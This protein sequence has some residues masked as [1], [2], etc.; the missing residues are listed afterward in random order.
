MKRITC[1]WL[2]AAALWIGAPEAEARYWLREYSPTGTSR[3]DGM[4][5][6]PDGGFLTAGTANADLWLSKMTRWGMMEWSTGY[7]AAAPTEGRAVLRTFDDGFLVV[8]SIRDDAVNLSTNVFVLRTDAEGVPLWA[9]SIGSQGDDAAVSVARTIGG[10]YL[11]GATG[12][13]T[14][15]GDDFYVM[16]LNDA[17][18]LIWQRFYGGA[19]HES[20]T[21]VGETF[22]GS[23]YI[24]GTTTSYGNGDRDLLLMRLAPD[25]VIENVMVVDVDGEGS[26]DVV[27]GVAEVDGAVVF[28]GSTEG[29]GLGG[30]DLMALRADPF[31]QKVQWLQLYG[32]GDDDM[33]GAVTATDQ[34]DL[35]VA[36]ATRSFNGAGA[37]DPWMLRLNPDDGSVLSEVAYQGL[38]DFEPSSVLFTPSA[39]NP[40]IIASGQLAGAQRGPGSVSTT[41]R[42]GPDGRVDPSCT[43]TTSTTSSTGQTTP[44]VSSPSVGSVVAGGSVGSVTTSQTTR[45]DNTTTACTSPPEP[46]SEPTPSDE[47]IEAQQ[48][49]GLNLEVGEAGPDLTCCD[50]APGRY[51]GASRFHVMA[52]AC[53]GLRDGEPMTAR[54]APAS[55]AGTGL[56]PDLP[57]LT[58]GCL[59]YA[60]LGE[61]VAGFASAAHFDFQGVPTPIELPPPL[62]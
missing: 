41:I 29:A 4:T 61:N 16:L 34:G 30:E 55:A 43:S 23:F 5:R 14:L 26:D 27:N 32:A 19:G 18:G 39:L 10:D 8:G 33:A 49:R 50:W 6:T 47:A 52:V 53:A 62:P 3:I 24:A 35:R 2:V 15:G 56:C 51:N 45:D 58:G 54:G 59:A 40:G 38:G 25:G 42:T 31:L 28:V 37:A 22:D 1:L 44:S 57:T 46:A 20:L 60:I 11:I 12:V 36:G 9:R 13:G 48:A 17:G 21:A 7:D